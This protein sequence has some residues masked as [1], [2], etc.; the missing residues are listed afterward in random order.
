MKKV[1]LGLFAVLFLSFIIAAQ[2]AAGQVYGVDPDLKVSPQT[3]L[4]DW[5]SNNPV[6]VLTVHADINW[7]TVHEL[8]VLLEKIPATFTKADNRG[9]LVAKFDWEEIKVYLEGLK[10]DG[11]EG[12]SETLTLTLTCDYTD[13]EGNTDNFEGKDTVRVVY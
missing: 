5:K 3:L 9:D 1:T 8:T 4:L 13:E 10:A 6:M 11:E 2:P 12:G 7:E